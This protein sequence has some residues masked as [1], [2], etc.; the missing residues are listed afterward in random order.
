[1]DILDENGRL[2]GVVNI[3]D[4]LVVLVVIAV[5]VAGAALVLGGDSEPEPE[6][7]PA[8]AY[9]TVDFGQQPSNVVAEINEGDSYS[10]SSDST[11]TITDVQVSPTGDQPHVTA[12]VELTGPPSD[13]LLEYDGA[14][15]RLG[16]DVTVATDLYSIDG[17]IETIGD[18]DALPSDSET[19]LLS[20][21]LSESETDAIAPGDAIQVAG[22]T[23][24]TIEDIVVYPDSEDRH[25]RVY[26]TVNASTY[27]QQDE[28]YIGQTPLR[29]GQTL[30]LPGDGYTVDGTI[31]RVGSGIDTSTANVTIRDTLDA[32][33]AERIDAGDTVSVSDDTV[34]T[35]E[36]VTT[37]GTDNPD[38]KDVILGVA[39]HTVTLDNRPYFGK[40][41]V[42]EG[43]S[44]T[45][46]TEAYDVNGEI[47][48]VGSLS[49]RGTE[50]TRTVT[51]RQT[52]VHEDMAS[53]IQPGMTERSGESELAEVT[54]VEDEPSVVLIQGQEGDLGVYDHP[55]ERDVTITADLQVRET[56]AGVQ[57]KGETIQQG[58][59]VTL[60]LGTVTVRA[61]I[62]DIR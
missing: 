15:P 37:Y 16:R 48:E 39:A 53:A 17:H 10:P 44:L 18:E 41:H 20:A 19:L 28:Q 49:P 32:T 56:T 43:N 42:Q 55:V 47:E 54:D 14:P 4:L 8:T 24:A 30:T 59:T 45:L 62:V 31:E 5:A 11:A 57:Y 36:S 61:E 3:V 2:F 9:A 60:D 51:L 1:M 22:R 13:D 58:S 52:E 35:V 23:S 27:S 21:T 12:R 40:T 6:P 34:A 29:D 26:L 25:N 7:E 50:A 46:N 33:T 38:R